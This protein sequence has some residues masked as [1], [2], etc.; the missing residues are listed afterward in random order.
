VD[1]N[2]RQVRDGTFYLDR[3]SDIQQKFNA[4][5]EGN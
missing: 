1:V 3:S 2:A 5:F 4:D